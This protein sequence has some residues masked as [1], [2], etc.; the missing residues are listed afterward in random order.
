MRRQPAKALLVDLDGVLRRWDPAVPAGVEAAYGLPPGALLDTAMQ[1]QLHRAA[2]TGDIS[3]ATWMEIVAE[4]LAPLAGDPQR[5]TAAV[6]EWQA[7]RGE[8]DPDVLALVREVRAAGL[9][10]GLATN[11]TDLLDGDLA[12][13]GLTGEVDTVVNSST[14]KI[15]KP[16]PDFFVRACE[17]IGVSAPWV[18]FVDDEDRNVRAARAGKL[19]AYRWTG[20]AGLPYLRAALDF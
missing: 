2:V 20:P 8:V 7:Y 14:I 15:H 3:H 10:V 9:P 13:L 1:W 11:G 12:R 17:A 4:R 16:A 5:A 18:L 19:L 6:T